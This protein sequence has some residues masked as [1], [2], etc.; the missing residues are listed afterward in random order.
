MLDGESADAAGL[1]SFVFLYVREALDKANS[2]FAGPTL[3]SNVEVVNMHHSS[4]GT[5]DK[6]D[7]VFLVGDDRAD[8]FGD[9]ANGISGAAMSAI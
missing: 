8:N 9:S 3:G 1:E 2:S 7:F 4:T 6:M 5:A